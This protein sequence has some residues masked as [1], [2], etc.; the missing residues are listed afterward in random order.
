MSCA[1]VRGSGAPQMAE[2]TAKPAAP[3]AT[4]CAAWRAFSPPIAT[5][6]TGDAA[7]AR[8]VL[9]PK[10]PIS[11][12]I[13]KVRASQR[14]DL[15]RPVLEDRQDLMPAIAALQDWVKG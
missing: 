15:F 7:V 9:D 4:T 11:P 3:A 6:G 5:L 1:A 12:C 2:T 13:L 14:G 10:L 8:I